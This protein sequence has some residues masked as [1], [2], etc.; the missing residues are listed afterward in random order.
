MMGD[1]SI[2]SSVFSLGSSKVR[3]VALLALAAFAA[4]GP[5]CGN[6]EGDGPAATGGTAGTAGTAGNAGTAGPGGG[7]GGTGGTGGHAGVGGSAGATGGAAG[8]AG[9]AGSAGSA[10][11]GGSGGGAVEPPISCGGQCVFVRPGAT[12][13]ASGADWENALPSLPTSLERGR[14]YLLADGEYGSYRFEDA[15]SGSELLTVRKATI[16]DHGTDVGWNDAYGD[17]VALFDGVRFATSHVLLEG[18]KG[19]GP[20]AW[21][22]GHGIE[23]VSI[24]AE[25]KDNGELIGFEPGAAYVT[26]AHVHA[27]A[28]NNDYPMNGV[29]GTGGNHH[30]TF[31]YDSIHTTFG[32]TFHIGDWSDVVIERSFLADVRSTGGDDPLCPDWHA[33]GISSIGTNTNITIRYNLWDEIGG[34][35]VIAGVNTGGSVDWQ[36]YGNVFARS[37]T[38]IR[39]YFDAQTTNQQ[40]MDGLRFYNNDIVRMPGSSVGTIAIDAG[41]DNRVVN[42]VWWDNVANTFVMSGVSHDY[43]LFAGNRRVEG[44]DPPCEK[45]EEG[46]ADE[47]HGQVGS[48]DLFVEAYGEPLISDCHLLGPTEPGQGLPAPFDDDPDGTPRGADGNWDRGAYEL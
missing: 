29:K 21:N 16:D 20:D 26:V 32:P 34:T 24:G 3:S 8:V 17:G 45:D 47:S 14:V 12:G 40:T 6:D 39:Y 28:Q 2:S 42:N 19:G 27:H 1:V 35:A 23:I 44:C 15:T 43:N 22:S 31:R 33:E 5:G 4:T 11:T 37:V 18:T 25:C 46:A 48:G 7:T 10:G 41:S 9:A 30:L 13:A 38:T 36:I